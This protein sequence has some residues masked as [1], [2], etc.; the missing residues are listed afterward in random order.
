MAYTT[1]DSATGVLV[2]S[3]TCVLPGR[4]TFTDHSLAVY[5][6]VYKAKIM[7]RLYDRSDH[8]DS[9]IIVNTKNSIR[10]DYDIAYLVCT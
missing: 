4:P 10:R 6:E 1:S 7:C 3:R 5:I 9:D 8:I 2:D